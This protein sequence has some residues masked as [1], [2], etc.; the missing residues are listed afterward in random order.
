MWKYQRKKNCYGS[1]DE[2]NTMGGLSSAK[3]Y[4]SGV[5]SR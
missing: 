3:L 5:S 4:D 1:W 2:E